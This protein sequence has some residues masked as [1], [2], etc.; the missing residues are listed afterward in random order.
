MA[1]LQPSLDPRR[2]LQIIE[3]LLEGR[4]SACFRGDADG[5]FFLLQTEG[6]LFQ[7]S[8]LTPD[9]RRRLSVSADGNLAAEGV[10]PDILRAGLALMAS[11]VD[12]VLARM[13][14][15]TPIPDE[16]VPD[17]LAVFDD[18]ALA[19]GRSLDDMY[20]DG[21]AAALLKAIRNAGSG[22]SPPPSGKS[23]GGITAE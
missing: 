6:S 19:E 15:A 23:D 8:L 7:V 20:A 9:G 13:S 21:A 10:H 14:K 22:A 5:H 16:M 17:I 2:R 1:E 18:L 4:S 3:R 11:S 12:T